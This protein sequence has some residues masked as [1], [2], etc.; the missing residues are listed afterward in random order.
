M[1]LISDNVRILLLFSLL[2]FLTFLQDCN[3]KI[4]KIESCTI[5]HFIHRIS[6]YDVN[7]TFR[8][9]SQIHNAH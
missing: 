3:N 6:E 8:N 9:C 5:Q 1:W 2:S 7:C 4:K